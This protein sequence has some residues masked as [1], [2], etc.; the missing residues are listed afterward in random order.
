VKQ[1]RDHIVICGFDDASIS[2]VVFLLERIYMFS[3]G[4][5]L[6]SCNYVA[7]LILRRRSSVWI[8]CKQASVYCGYSSHNY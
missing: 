3:Y 1:F 5:Y 7:W 6:L 4:E 2:D 8:S